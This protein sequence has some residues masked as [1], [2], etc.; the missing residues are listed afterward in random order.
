MN[1]KSI[2]LSIVIIMVLALASYFAIG[3]RILD[4]PADVKQASEF[5]AGKNA[6]DCPFKGN[7]SAKISANSA[8]CTP[9][10]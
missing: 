7:K 8:C 5:C 4:K 3:A 2:I 1:K 6:A 10:K 9:S